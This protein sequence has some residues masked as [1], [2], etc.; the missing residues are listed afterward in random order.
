MSIIHRTLICLDVR[1]LKVARPKAD[2]SF[3]MYVRERPTIVLEDLNIALLLGAPSDQD[4]QGFQ[5]L[6]KQFVISSCDHQ[7]PNRESNLHGYFRDN[8]KIKATM[9][10]ELGLPGVKH[11]L[12]EPPSR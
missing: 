5:P 4:N 8:M 10:A 2:P 7:Q 9:R 1:F 3:T 11:N 6:A 12:R